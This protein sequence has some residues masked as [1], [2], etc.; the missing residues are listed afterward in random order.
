MLSIDMLPARHG[1]CLWIEYG[2]GRDQH[3]ILVDGGPGFA[4]QAL[5][6]R[7]AALPQRERHFELLVVSHID[8]DHIEGIIRLLGD[9]ALGVTFGDVWFNGWKQISGGMP[10]PFGAETG[11]YLSALI[12]KL[13]LPWN[14]AFG[15]ANDASGHVLKPVAAMMREAPIT[16]AGGARLT[17]LSPSKPKLAKLRAAWQKELEAAGL[18]P[19]A[20][21]EALER[22]KHSPRFA[23]VSFGT[24]I[25]PKTLAA[26]PFAMDQAAANGSSI[27]F[28][29][30]AGGK[31]ALLLADAHPDVLVEAI[32]HVRGSRAKLEVDAVKL[33]H[34]GSRNNVSAALVKMI[35]AERWLFSSDGTFFNHPDPE[36]VS[37]VITE[38]KQP[39]L[40]FNYRT[41]RT[42]I[43][44]D[45]AL[46]K[47]FG[48][49]ALYPTGKPG[50]ALEL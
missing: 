3:R 46:K 22:L 19:D 30:E 31:R 14:Q 35:A 27:A 23:G 9:S 10:A 37:R 24:A 13:R 43:W 16:L 34:H 36:A 17:V 20:P 49:R 48:Y 21:E 18:D 38:S 39:L 50:L 40:A 12:P 44:D 5:R 41:K 33:P 6:E 4:Y 47:R 25:E 11:E 42:A 26:Q 28:L 8:A 2:Q 7:I 15:Q 29:L 45:A 1:D 32:E